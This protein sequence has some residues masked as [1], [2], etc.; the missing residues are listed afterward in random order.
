ME[1][2]LSFLPTGFAPEGVAALAFAVFKI[3]RELRV[4]ICLLLKD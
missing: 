3:G 4:K 1:R 2:L